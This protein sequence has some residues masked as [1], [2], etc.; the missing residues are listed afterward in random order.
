MTASIYPVA[1]AALAFLSVLG[2]SVG[3]AGL[4]RQRR[5]SRAVRAKLGMDAEARKGRRLLAG[6][7]RRLGEK[8]GPHDEEESTGL[9]AALARAGLRSP[10]APMVYWGVKCL[11]MLVLLG[12]FLALRLLVLHTLPLPATLTAGATAALAGLYLPGLW[13]HA[14][15]SERRKAFTNGLPDALDLLVVCVES[16]MGLDQ[17]LYRV[18][19]EMA[20]DCLVIN[21]EFR[22][23]NLELRAGKAR[24]DALRSLA[25]RVGLDDVNSLVTLLIQSDAFGTSVA[26]TLRV[27][28]D[29]MRTKRYQRAEE[30]AAKLPVKLLVPLVTFIFPA[31]FVVIGGPAVISLLGVFGAGK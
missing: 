8:T 12:A 7:A 2:L 22:I 1:A 26:Q 20:H 3:T 19:V 23:L 9:R 27:Y 16:G 21:E 14:R 15:T 24:A 28:S 29:V 31:L 4:L 11:C 10:N 30:M 18:G 6:L 17:A 25:E 5:R 13:L